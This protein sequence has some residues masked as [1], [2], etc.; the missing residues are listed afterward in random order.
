MPAA[1]F[2]LPL[3][4]LFL[5]PIYPTINSVALSALPKHR[6]APMTGLIE[7][8]SALGGTTGS[9]LT[10]QRFA[11]AGG[12][13][14]FYLTLAPMALLVVAVLALRCRSIATTEWRPVRPAMRGLACVARACMVR[15]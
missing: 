13:G 5:A 2:A 6:H 4:G 14:A 3:I 8:F 15:A 9:F 11:R 12:Q 10:G 1:A 7:V